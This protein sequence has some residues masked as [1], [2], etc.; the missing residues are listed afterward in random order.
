MVSE[1]TRAVNHFVGI[2]A[3]KATA[4]QKRGTKQ[5]GY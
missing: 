1:M 5:Y 2:Y 4:I 3:H